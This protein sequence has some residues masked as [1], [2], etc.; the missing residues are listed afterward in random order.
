MSPTLREYQAW[1]VRSITKIGHTSGP[2]PMELLHSCFVC[3]FYFPWLLQW[4]MCWYKRPNF[5]LQNGQMLWLAS[6]CLRS[7]FF[8]LCLNEHCSQWYSALFLLWMFWLKSRS[9]LVR[10]SLNISNAGDWGMCKIVVFT[11][12]D[13][14]SKTICPLQNNWAMWTLHLSL[15]G[16]RRRRR[17]SRSHDNNDAKVILIRQETKNWIY[18]GLGGLVLCRECFHWSS[19]CDKTWD[20]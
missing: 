16:G 3:D 7:S 15:R 8:S 20:P 1:A 4:G 17:L 2:F 11:H 12:L 14:L 5:C 10:I 13:M 18:G 19:I 6:S 9:Q